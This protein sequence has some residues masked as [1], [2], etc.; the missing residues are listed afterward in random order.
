MSSRINSLGLMGRA[1][2]IVTV[3][4]LILA[5]VGGFLL[6]L[7]IAEQMLQTQCLVRAVTSRSGPKIG[8]IWAWEARHGV[9]GR[10]FE[11][12][13]REVCPSPA[14]F[15]GSFPLGARFY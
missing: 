6:G 13:G 10:L 2:L 9:R 5:L 8:R 14:T 7:W 15:R 12:A 11:G 4:V 3:I 1:R